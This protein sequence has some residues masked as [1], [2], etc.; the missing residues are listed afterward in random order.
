[1]KVQ[2]RSIYWLRGARANVWPVSRATNL[3]EKI[4]SC[5]LSASYTLTASQPTIAPNPVKN[6]P[7]REL[8]QGTSSETTD[9]VNLQNVP[10]A[11][12]TIC[13]PSCGQS[14][15]K[16]GLE[17]PHCRPVVF[18]TRP[19]LNLPTSPVLPQ[20]LFL[21]KSAMPRAAPDTRAS[22]V[23]E[24]QPQHDMARPRR[25]AFVRQALLIIWPCGV[26]TCCRKAGTW[27]GA[28][29]ETAAGAKPGSGLMPITCTKQHMGALKY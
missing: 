18:F 24:L 16:A 5:I 26:Q 1:M 4:L 15:E 12:A 8:T 2:R 3:P 9:P 20:R 6:K 10:L 27:A 13:T 17:Q 28:K 23:R 29:R 14:T 21:P 22:C 7:Q 25:R 11:P 19:N